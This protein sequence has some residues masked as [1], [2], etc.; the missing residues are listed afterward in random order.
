MRD[1]G[2]GYEPEMLVLG[3][4]L[5]FEWIVPEPF[6]FLARP[7]NAGSGYEIIFLPYTL[8][9]HLLFSYVTLNKSFGSKCQKCFS[10]YF[11]SP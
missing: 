5:G 2:S 6:A 4:R 10:I 8:G 11:L 3:T 7:G 9:L 1:A